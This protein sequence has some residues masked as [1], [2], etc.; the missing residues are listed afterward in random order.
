V[1]GVGR[2]ARRVNEVGGEKINGASTNESLGF[3][4]KVH[5]TSKLI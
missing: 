1:Q 5:G 3:G 2:H 4:T